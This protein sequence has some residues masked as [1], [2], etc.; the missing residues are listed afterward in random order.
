[1]PRQASH[2]PGRPHGRADSGADD[3]IRQSERSAAN[4]GCSAGV[5]HTDD[6]TPEH[7]DRCTDRYGTPEGDSIV[8]HDAHRKPDE[9]QRWDHRS[10]RE[11]K[12]CPTLGTRVHRYRTVPAFRDTPVPRRGA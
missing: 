6:D 8:D 11:L 9:Q 1:M 3:N 5:S 7:R 10:S 2:S 4:S 12:P